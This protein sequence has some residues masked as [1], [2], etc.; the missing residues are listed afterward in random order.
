MSRTYTYSSAIRIILGAAAVAISAACRDATTAFG[1]TTA[2]ARNNTDQLYGGIA[3]RFTNVER[4]PKF[5]IA[6]GKLGKNALTPSVIYNDTSVWTAMNSD[7]SRVVTVE[8]EF[9]N[10][11][12]VFSA[13]PTATA[14]NEPGDSRHTMVLR[15][16][17]DDEYDW[18]T[19]VEIAAGS[20]TAND[21]RNVLSAWMRSAEKRSPGVIRD[22]YRSS[23]PRATAS[24]GRLFSLD[25][26]RVTNDPD[27]ATTI[28]LGI[29]LSPAKLRPIMPAFADYLD[30]YGK[31][32]K[33]KSVVLDK[34]GTRWV[35]L[36]GEKNFM[37]LKLRSIGGH[38][39]PLSGQ[40]R[41]IP[42]DLLIDSEFTTK[43]L[44]FHVGFRKFIGNVTVIDG[45]H[46]RGWFI[47]FTKEPDW[48]L[49]PVV[50]TLIK[51][52]LRRPFEKDGIMFR[53]A[54]QDAPG[55]QS[56][57]ARRTSA[58]VQESAILRFLNRLSGTA[59]GDFV[60]KAETE[61]N[62]FSAEVF[63]A[64]KADARSLLQ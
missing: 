31:E 49:P 62:R 25:S 59:M 37:T 12:Y 50:G 24:L 35:E 39:A 33:Y 22:D 14:A 26:L 45:E 20:V 60:G 38:F 5:R 48:K 29:R 30:K 64:L 6:R 13:K 19:N 34:R 57:I 28:Y 18:F 61:E 40:L 3:Q 47:R 36:A 2:S 23:A 16:I 46:E 9:G 27:G 4:N 7:N 1:P 56:I 32:S 52:P 54:L 58:T 44:L 42:N 11:K 53:L 10:N 17:S 15:K 55:R 8:G 21:L 51:T 63:T 43:I 41:P